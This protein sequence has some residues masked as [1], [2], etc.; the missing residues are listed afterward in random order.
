MDGAYV[1]TVNAVLG[2]NR[3]YSMGFKG[4]DYSMG[5]KGET[6]ETGARS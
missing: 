2:Q 6:G 5:C 4:A 3:N 1:Y